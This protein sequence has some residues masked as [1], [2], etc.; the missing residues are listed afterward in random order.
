MTSRVLMVVPTLGQRVERLG[1]CLES[2][3]SQD[4]APIDLV[5]VAPASAEVDALAERYGGRVVPDPRPGY[6]GP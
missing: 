4:N 2:I 3:A 1:L 5:L 6:P